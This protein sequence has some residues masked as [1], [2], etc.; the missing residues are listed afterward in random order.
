MPK[1]ILAKTILNKT[2]RRDPWFLDEYTSNAWSGC[3]MNCLYCYIRGSKYGENMAEGLSVKTNAVDLF[4]KELGRRA[5]KGQHGIIV[6]SS[7]TDPYPHFEETQKTTRRFLEII[8]E[9]RFPLHVI[10]K[11]DLVLRDL[12]L[13]KEIGRMAIFP[14]DL[15]GVLK[16]RVFISFSFSTFDQEISKIFEPGAPE[17]ARR[18]RAMKT[19]G[20]S[21]LLTGASLMPLLPFISDT[22][23]ALEKAVNELHSHGARYAFPATLT[24]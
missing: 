15:E 24:L 7:A 8:L 3:P 18:L 23:E 9:N 13:L 20:E 5:A 11:S 2:Q 22:P 14:K 10:T 19:L 12:D 1:E 6:L 4:E 17:P 16:H 21:G